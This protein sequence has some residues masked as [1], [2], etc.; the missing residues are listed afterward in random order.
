MLGLVALA[1]TG[2]SLRGARQM[3]RPTASWAPVEAPDGN[4][5]DFGYIS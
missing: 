1:R 2:N 4:S 3:R 5:Q